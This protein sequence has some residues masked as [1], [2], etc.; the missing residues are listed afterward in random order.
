MNKICPPN[1][2]DDLCLGFC[3]NPSSMVCALSR[4]LRSCLHLS[5]PSILFSVL[6][7]LPNY[8]MLYTE[9]GHEYHHIHSHYRTQ[10]YS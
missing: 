9:E 5:L 8:F 2:R 6:F 1:R 3:L 10:V 7:T 4:S